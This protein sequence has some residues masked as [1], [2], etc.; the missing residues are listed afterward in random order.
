MGEAS[1]PPPI[2]AKP[3]KTLQSPRNRKGHERGKLQQADILTS[4]RSHLPAVGIVFQG[5][6]RA[7]HIVHARNSASAGGEDSAISKL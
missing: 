1:A 6:L 4:P 5:I 2:A 3:Q 7:E